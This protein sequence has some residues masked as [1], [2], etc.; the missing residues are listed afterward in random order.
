MLCGVY[1]SN[2]MYPRLACDDADTLP[3]VSSNAPLAMK[4]GKVYSCVLVR[5]VNR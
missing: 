2:I 3:C 4:R 1:E 5:G